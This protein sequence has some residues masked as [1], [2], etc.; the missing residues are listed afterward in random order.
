MEMPLS[1]F[2]F[3]LETAVERV[4]VVSER[5]TK[6]SLQCLIQLPVFHFQIF[7][8][9]EGASKVTCGIK[10]VKSWP[11]KTRLTVHVL[12]AK[13]L[14][15]LLQNGNVVFQVVGPAGQLHPG[16]TFLSAYFWWLY[17][18]TIVFEI[19]LE[20]LHRDTLWSDDF[21]SVNE[22]ADSAHR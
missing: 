22:V 13:S 14:T 4:A 21:E 20:L 12:L 17:I 5:H 9:I 1:S 3:I 8:C 6:L 11:I 2:A 10:L 18:Q 7:G 19:T 16:V 15:C